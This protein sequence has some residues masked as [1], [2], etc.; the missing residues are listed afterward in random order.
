MSL[1]GFLEFGG[2][3]VIRGILSG[4]TADERRGAAGG[5]LDVQSRVEQTLVRKGLDR[6]RYGEA[7]IRDVIRRAA[8]SMNAAADLTR[9]V[10]V[11]FGENPIPLFPL[12]GI[13][14]GY[15]YLVKLT[16]QNPDGS[17]FDMIV[18]VNS[19]QPLR[20]DQVIEQAVD[21]V[22]DQ[23][24]IRSDPSGGTGR[25]TTLLGAAPIAVYSGEVIR[26]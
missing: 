3:A 15:T 12:Q 2:E 16:Y 19:F 6:F 10:R 21:N 17:S 1:L 7:E 18:D 4:Y 22:G 20:L 24:N 14:R 8:Q 9:G 26:P 25:T 23:L 5:N 11:G 13:E